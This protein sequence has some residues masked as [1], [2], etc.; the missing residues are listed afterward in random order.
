MCKVIHIDDI[1]LN[2]LKT[3]DF[4]GTLDEIGNQPDVMPALLEL[5]ERQTKDIDR[6]CDIIEQDRRRLSQCYSRIE[7]LEDDLFFKHDIATGQY[8]I[9]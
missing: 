7:S 1:K 4:K 8:T 9:D 5:V 3:R 2:Q 6:L